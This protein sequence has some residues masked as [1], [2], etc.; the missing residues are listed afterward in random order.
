M[1]T[2]DFKISVKFLMI[3]NKK[4]TISFFKQI[5]VVYV[6]KLLNN[7]VLGWVSV[8]SETSYYKRHRP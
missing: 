6:G 2:K 4:V 1:E 8:T 5:K 7:D 3:D